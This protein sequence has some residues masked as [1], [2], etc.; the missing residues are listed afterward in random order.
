MD[1]RQITE[2]MTEAR[3]R[4]VNERKRT[5]RVFYLSPTDLAE[6]ERTDPP[7]VE[8]MFAL[9]LGHKPSP[10]TCPAFDGIAVRPTRAKP[11]A[12]GRVTSKLISQCG[13]TVSVPFQ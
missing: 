13:V 5:P 1:R 10:M 11:D 8:A 3:A 7:T 9:P 2:R 4:M 6:F 12:R